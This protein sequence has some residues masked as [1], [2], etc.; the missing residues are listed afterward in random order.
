VHRLSREVADDREVNEEHEG[1][2]D[3]QVVNEGRD[4]ERK[5]RPRCDD[6][7]P[8]SPP[9]PVE[10][11]P[12]LDERERPVGDQ[13]DHDGPQRAPARSLDGQIG[14]AKAPGMR[15]VP[16]VLRKPEEVV[17]EAHLHHDE[18]GHGEDKPENSL[19]ELVRDDEYEAALSPHGG[20]CRLELM[21][22]HR[23]Q[24]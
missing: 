19:D 3:V 14:E 22:A 18:N 1:S 24:F 15:V 23:G 5:K 2:H 12:A 10:E 16:Q 4:F 6:D 20:D 17:S 7:E 13:S 11:R 21:A 9:L 8:R